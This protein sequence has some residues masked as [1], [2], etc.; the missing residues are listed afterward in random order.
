MT[1]PDATAELGAD[2]P[3]STHRLSMLHQRWR[4]P[5]GVLELL[6][7]AGIVLLAVWCWGHGIVRIEYSTTGST[8]P[9]VGTR[10]LGNWIGAAVGL[11]VLAG[12]L[13]LDALRELSLG[14]RSRGRNRRDPALTDDQPV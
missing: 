7:A 8:E 9:A 3:A 4:V 6:L 10:Y 13:L 14:I 11:C 12:F 1:T 5:L 2:R